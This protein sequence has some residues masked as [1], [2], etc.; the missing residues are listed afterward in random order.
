MLCWEYFDRNAKQKKLSCCAC[1][2]LAYSRLGPFYS[3]YG[4]AKVFF[5]LFWDGWKSADM[6]G[7]LV[8]LTISPFQNI[9][10]RLD[11]THPIVYRLCS[12]S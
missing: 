3:V 12:I 10:V 11:G 4:F 6:L 2:P 9:I 8:I 1:A 5:Y 7:Q